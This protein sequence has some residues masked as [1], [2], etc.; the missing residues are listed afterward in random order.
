MGF[1]V[2]VFGSAMPSDGESEDPAPAPEPE[3]EPAPAPAPARAP[4]GTRAARPRVYRHI[5]YRERD[6]DGRRFAVLPAIM[7]YNRE[8]NRM[9]ESD[10][11][12]TEAVLAMVLDFLGEEIQANTHLRTRLFRLEHPRS[13][14]E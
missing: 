9:R 10:I 5:R 8:R 14:D 3:P 4:R 13:D 12:S 6:A 7:R 11:V 1:P 2:P